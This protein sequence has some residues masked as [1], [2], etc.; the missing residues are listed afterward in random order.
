MHVHC[1]QIQYKVSKGHAVLNA[2][3][4]ALSFFL[5]WHRVGTWQVQR[6]RCTSDVACVWRREGETQRE[7]EREEEKHLLFSSMVI[8]FA[9][10]TCQSLLMVIACGKCPL[11]FVY[12]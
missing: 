2:D 8:C 7:T 4:L 3:V 5:F 1:N 9:P 6:T 12:Y 11:G 10:V